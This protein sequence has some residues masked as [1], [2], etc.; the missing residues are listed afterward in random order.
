ML[1]RNAFNALLKTLE[2]PPEHTK[3]VFAT[4]ELRKIPV[5]VLSRC[6]RF[7]LRRVE[8]A[9]LARHFTAVAEQ[10][11]TVL[12]APAAALLA[13]A[14][15]GSVRDG[16]SLLDQAIVLA[17]AAGEGTPMAAAV[18][19]GLV[20]GM[21]GLADRD[22]VTDLF[23]AVMQGGI[24]KALAQYAE[25]H[26]GGA[27]PLTVLQDLLEL[28]HAVTRH[29]LGTEPDDAVGA[30]TARLAG[31]A[32]ALPVPALTRAWQILLKGVAEVQHAS[33]GRAALDMVLVRL[34]FVADLPSP[35]DLVRRLAG[36]PAGA[37]HAAAPAG[38]PA[39]AGAP[40]GRGTA[41][42]V[43]AGLASARV[44]PQ[45]D[46]P[47]AD[48]PLA[49]APLPAAAPAA[50]PAVGLA[51]PQSFADLVELFGARREPVLRGH[52]VAN[53][54]LVHFE[55]GRLEFR[56]S[57]QAP[58]DLAQ[59]VGQRLADWTGRRWVISLA[60][61]GG[62]ATLRQQTEA[63]AAR[64]L[65]AAAAHPLVQAVLDAFPGARI[66]A[67]RPL[68]PGEEPD[69]AATLVTDDAEDAAD[70]S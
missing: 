70:G 21:L 12:E 52:L 8:P 51:D 50:V 5:T 65:D 23:E 69:A 22:A 47:L 45:P 10:E 40:V 38:A 1:S 14:A 25:L 59:L 6:Q 2:E 15:D 27:D 36:A 58:R 9:E 20:R 16:L 13:R 42:A 54:H 61:A 29:K 30:E 39:A 11:G 43:G 68:K 53:V 66:E 37:A 35:A 46:P 31:L 24:A 17:A 44:A 63:T 67:V 56:P 19:A 28:C 60:S 4:T 26:R 3:F 48:P 55:P 49:A 64:R 41:M 62:A 34:A 32:E 57:E 33:D 7:D 18:D